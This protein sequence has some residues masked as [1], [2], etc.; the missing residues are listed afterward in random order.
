MTSIADRV[1]GLLL[2]QGS[3]AEGFLNQ[4]LVWFDDLEKYNHLAKQARRH[5]ENFAFWERNYKVLLNSIVD[6][7]PR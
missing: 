5:Y 6:E 4:I 2:D 7:L 1:S 3:T